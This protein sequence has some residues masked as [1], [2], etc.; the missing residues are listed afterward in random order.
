MEWKNRIVRKMHID[1]S[2]LSTASVSH[3]IIVK[4]IVNLLQ[5]A[6]TWPNTRES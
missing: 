3:L 1:S 5:Q 2:A 4:Y 6:P